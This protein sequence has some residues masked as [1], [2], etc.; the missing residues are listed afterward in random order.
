MKGE[1][2]MFIKK[3]EDI[4]KLKDIKSVTW[5]ECP[6]GVETEI[7]CSTCAVNIELLSGCYFAQQW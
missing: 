6:N 7:Y 4:A 3:I 1:H 5:G 2:E